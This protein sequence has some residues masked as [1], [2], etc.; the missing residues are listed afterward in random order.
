MCTELHLDGLLASLGAAVECGAP[1]GPGG[2][3][4]LAFK[5]TREEPIRIAWQRSSWLLER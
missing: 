5:Q 4:A 1:N 2:C 3:S